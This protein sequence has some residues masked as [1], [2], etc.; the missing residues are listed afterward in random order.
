MYRF[1]GTRSVLS[2]ET[3]VHYPRYKLRGQIHL[4]DTT[5]FFVGLR[6]AFCFLIL[7]LHCRF[8]SFILKFL[9]L[10]FERTRRTTIL[11]RIFFFFR[12]CSFLWNECFCS[13]QFSVLFEFLFFPGYVQISLF[14]FCSFMCNKHFTN[15]FMF[16][17]Y[18]LQFFRFCSSF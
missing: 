18:L 14:R 2:W 7:C 9:F 3:I 4:K 8:V 13:L 17:S 12:F 11:R 10:F 6:S 16:V 5:L 15:L 1:G